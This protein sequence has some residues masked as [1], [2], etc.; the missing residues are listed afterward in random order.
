MN[1]KETTRVK[2]E[3]IVANE[4]L[5]NVYEACVYRKE[6]KNPNKCLDYIE[7][8]VKKTIDKLSK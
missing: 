7:N 2:N 6:M 8:I 3:L 4:T 5:E 1:D